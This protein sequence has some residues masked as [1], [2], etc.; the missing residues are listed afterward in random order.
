MISGVSSSYASY[1]TSSTLARTQNA[2]SSTATQSGSTGGSQ[3][4]AKF[5]EDLFKSID[6]DGDGSLSK[7]ELTSA[8]SSSDDSENSDIDIDALLSELDSDGSG[9]ISQD[10]LSAALPPPPP[11]AGMGGPG[12]SAADLIS[13][14][15]TDG[16][17]SIS[18][19]E[20]AALGSSD[21]SELFTQLD[22]DG[23]GAISRDE[24][25]SALQAS[26]S[27]GPPPPPPSASG[28]SSSDTTGSFSDNASTSAPGHANTDAAYQKLVT[29]LLKQYQS[30][31]ATALQA[32]SG[33][34]VNI[35]A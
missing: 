14:L 35:A 18:S 5:Q 21:D 8:L 20:L 13:E 33:S 26:G 17:G 28:A 9:S 22:S 6:S 19:D 1:Y 29:N 10:E 4:A 2:N 15:D 23:S 7:D 11:P 34:L 32:S 30:S 31:Q 12:E 16:D 27:D 24:L 3:G 25:S